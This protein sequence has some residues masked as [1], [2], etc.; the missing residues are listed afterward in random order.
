MRTHTNTRPDKFYEPD[1][2]DTRVDTVCIAECCDGAITP[3]V[4][5][6]QELAVAKLLQW[7]LNSITFYHFAETILGMSLQGLRVD[8]TQNPQLYEY[9]C[10]I[11]CHIALKGTLSGARASRLL[12]GVSHC[13]VRWV[14]V[15]R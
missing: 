10:E 9:L 14:N 1:I 6:K 3:N 5:K 13:A 2:R 8:G 11:F 7:K 15:C 4:I 12:L